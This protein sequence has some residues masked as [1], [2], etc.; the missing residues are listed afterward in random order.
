MNIATLL[1]PTPGMGWA[2]QE[3]RSLFDRIRSNHFLALALIHY[4]WP[5]S[6]SIL[7][8]VGD[9]ISVQETHAG[10]RPLCHVRDR[11]DATAAYTSA[12][13]Q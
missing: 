6:E 1:D 13:H 3:R 11:T 8:S 9:V 10:C 12:F 5:V 4:S 2:L 7:H